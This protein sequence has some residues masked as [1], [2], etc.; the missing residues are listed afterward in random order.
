M[1]LPVST[2]ESLAM[3]APSPQTPK[4][5]DLEDRPFLGIYTGAQG[6]PGPTRSGEERDL[7]RADGIWGGCEDK[8]SLSAMQEPKPPPSLPSPPQQRQGTSRFPKVMEQERQCWGHP[9]R[10]SVAMGSH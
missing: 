9:D 8:I 5:G 10:G 2:T 1:Q 7:F 4:W 6:A 3:W